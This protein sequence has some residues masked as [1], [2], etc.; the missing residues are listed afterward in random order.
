MTIYNHPGEGAGD[1]VPKQVGHSLLSGQ[2]RTKDM[3]IE[4][5]SVRK[6]GEWVQR[7]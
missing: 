3:G 5:Q 7:M 1:Q 4:V 6:A 2:K